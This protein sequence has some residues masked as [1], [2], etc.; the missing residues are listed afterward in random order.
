LWIRGLLETSSTGEEKRLLA[1]GA[2]DT[3]TS[4]TINNQETVK[5]IH[6]A[7]CVWITFLSW[8]VK[9]K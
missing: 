8:C 7:A 6:N 4:L 9:L 5:V 2:R 1:P 3:F